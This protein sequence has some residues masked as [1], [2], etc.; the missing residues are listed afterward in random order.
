MIGLLTAF[1]KEASYEYGDLIWGS[2]SPRQMADLMVY[3]IS[4]TDTNSHEYGPHS[5]EVHMEIDKAIG[6]LADTIRFYKMYSNL[7]LYVIISADHSQSEVTRFSNLPEDFK[8]MLGKTHKIAGQEDRAD[9]DRVSAAEVILANNDRAAFFYV[10]EDPVKKSET[11]NTI[12]D[13]LKK[14]QDVDLIFF[15]EDGVI[16]VIQV[17]TGG[18]PTGPSDICTFFKGKEP[19]YPNAVERLEGL[20][21]GDK[22]GDIVISMKEGYSMNPKFRTPHADEEMLHGDHGGL[23]SSDSLVPLLIWGPMIK[24]NVKD[25]TWKTFR[26]VDIAPTIAAIF[27]DTHPKTDGQSLGEIFIDEK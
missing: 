20:M 13:F 5:P 3:W 14:R 6:K 23:N 1:Y 9:T 7:P 16:Q 24:P 8:Q 4:D 10:F 12:M 26:T 25:G 21:K 17:P 11:L 19:L 2:A 15:E 22:W 27:K 18:P